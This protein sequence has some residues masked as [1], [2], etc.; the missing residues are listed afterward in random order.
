MDVCK[1]VWLFKT[2]FFFC[3]FHLLLFFV[4]VVD[5]CPFYPSAGAFFNGFI[6]IARTKLSGLQHNCRWEAYCEKAD[7]LNVKSILR[8]KWP[9][10]NIDLWFRD[11]IFKQLIAGNWSNVLTSSNYEVILW[12]WNSNRYLLRESQLFF[13]IMPDDW[14]KK[15]WKIF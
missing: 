15:L 11:T 1:N 5:S 2:S 7:V 4:C 13:L 9:R 6:A 10:K 14:L 3:C 12:F 8:G